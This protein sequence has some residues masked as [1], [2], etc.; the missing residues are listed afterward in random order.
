MVEGRQRERTSV[1]RKWGKGKD[2]YSFLWK[3]KVGKKNEGIASPFKPATGTLIFY[4]EAKHSI[5]HNS[6]QT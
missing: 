5:E 3:R 4:W 6:R 1:K 2:F